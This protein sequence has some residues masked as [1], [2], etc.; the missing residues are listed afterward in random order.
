MRLLSNEQDKFL[1]ENV[2]GL[3]NQELTDLIN[4]KY[5]TNFTINQIRGYKNNHHILS[6]LN[7]RFQK[8]H[9]PVNKGKKWNDYLTKEQQEKLKETMFKKGHR[10]ANYRP[11]GSERINC[12]G[13]IEIKVKDPNIWRLKHQV[14]Y[15]GKFGPIP[16]GFKVIFKDK[17][18]L[19]LDIEN[20][21]LVSNNEEFILNQENLIYA[22]KELT[23]AGIL[24]AKLKDRQNKIL[25]NRKGE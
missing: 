11:V 9:K 2:R 24:V 13:Y 8:G 5:H 20:L 7:C 18:R 15:E 16:K 17:N 19:N 25:K 22:S 21:A 3:T 4:K 23:E 6:G 12:Y 14:V 1:R 10:P